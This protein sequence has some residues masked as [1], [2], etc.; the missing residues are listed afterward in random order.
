MQRRSQVPGN[1]LRKNFRE[2]G[3]TESSGPFSG[4][5]TNHEETTRSDVLRQTLQ[6]GAL[7]RGWEIV[8]HVKKQDVSGKRKIVA[9]IAVAKINAVVIESSDVCSATNFSHIAIQS[10]HLGMKTA[11]S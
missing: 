6:K 11:L 10:R 9:N 7:I 3:Q 8:K 4:T 5:I 1:P 2:I